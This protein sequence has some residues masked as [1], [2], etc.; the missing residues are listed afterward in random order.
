MR[1]QVKYFTYIIKSD[2]D[3]GY[4]FGST[5][6]LESRIK[7]HNSGKVRSTKGRRPWRLH[8]HEAYDTRSEAVKREYFF[9][10]ISGYT[11]LKNSDII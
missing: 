6:N 9:K 11:W 8:Y 3:G 2:H 1:S 5:S 7:I 10:S 4:Y